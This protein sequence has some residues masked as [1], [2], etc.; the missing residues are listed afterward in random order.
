[1]NT[2]QVRIRA[3]SPG[4]SH[5]QASMM[6]QQQQSASVL[7]EF[8]KLA[9]K[10]GK[11][12]ENDKTDKEREKEY[13]D[14]KEEQPDE[15]KEYKYPG[16]KHDREDNKE[17]RMRDIKQLQSQLKELHRKVTGTNPAPTIQDVG[18]HYTLKNHTGELP[19]SVPFSNDWNYLNNTALDVI[20]SMQ[21]KGYPAACIDELRV[22]IANAKYDLKKEG[23]QP[24]YNPK[25]VHS[26]FA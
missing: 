9:R 14:E 6:S 13:L 21:A 15:M 10:E 2:Q 19:K 7:G 23:I 26:T 3:L 18:G 20:A 25:S 5:L 1:M 22:S 11:V 8:L 24:P 12:E 17:S 4:E 16:D